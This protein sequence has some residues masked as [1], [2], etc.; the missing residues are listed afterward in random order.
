VPFVPR[1]TSPLGVLEGVFYALVAFLLCATGISMAY[2]SRARQ[3]ARELA[4]TNQALS[5]SLTHLQMELQS[6]TD[7]LTR[8]SAPRPVEARTEA[9]SRPKVKAR[10]VAARQVPAVKRTDSSSSAASASR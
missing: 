4:A 7:R 8:L 2:L 10:V 6:V 1:P 3:Q 5:T 9:P